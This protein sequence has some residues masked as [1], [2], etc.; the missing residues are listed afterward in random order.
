M[1]YRISEKDGKGEINKLLI[2][3]RDTERVAEKKK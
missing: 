2:H 3:Q 1:G